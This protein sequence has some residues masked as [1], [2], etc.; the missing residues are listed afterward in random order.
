MPPH[1][2]ARLTPRDPPARLTPRRRAFEYHMPWDATGLVGD[3]DQTGLTEQMSHCRQQMEGFFGRPGDEAAAAPPG[4]RLQQALSEATARHE[5][6]LRRVAVLLGEELGKQL[7]AAVRR[8]VEEAVPEHPRSPGRERPGLFRNSSMKERSSLTSAEELGPS[9]ESER[10]TGGR[11]STM[12]LHADALLNPTR[13]FD[14]AA[15]T[16]LSAH[17]FGVGK[18]ASSTVEIVENTITGCC[19]EPEP[20]RTGG[21]ATIVLS[22]PFWILCN[23]VIALNSAFIIWATNHS[24]DTNGKASNLQVLIEPIFAAWYVV[25]LALK[26]AVH[27]KFFFTNKDL[28]FNILD[29]FLVTLALIE[30]F[31][32]LI[33][34]EQQ[35]FDATFLR[36]LRIFK[37]ARVL[38]MFRAVR[39]FADF[40]IMMDCV[41]Y[42]LWPLV[43]AIALLTFLSG[44][45]AI[46]FVQ[47]FA[48]ALESGEMDS[49]DVDRLL[50]AFGS[51]EA[52]MLSLLMA[53]T[54]GEDWVKLYDTLRPLG[55]FALGIFI[56]YIAFM[57]VAVMNIV[58]SVFLDKAMTIAQPN[59]E[60]VMLTKRE[61]DMADTKE[62]TELVSQMDTQKKGVITFSDFQQFMQTPK[63]RLY[64]D[65]RG[66]NVKDTAMFFRMLASSALTRPVEGREDHV[67]DLHSFVA[68]CMRLKG[69]ASSMDM[70][71][72]S[73]EM[74]ILRNT[75]EKVIEWMD[76][77]F[78][79]LKEAAGLPEESPHRVASLR[80]R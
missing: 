9:G 71:T 76:L 36:T 32:N 28:W 63:F 42:S 47:M 80:S 15:F 77:Q 33:E 64:F 79:Q 57:H 27:R 31:L 30:I 41:V 8:A 7:G 78:R 24:I 66:L 55:D 50:D 14:K 11:S 16:S 18:I 10:I 62:L 20:P 29:L 17:T 35:G 38:R 65:V 23:F 48:V 73:W 1:G 3:V 68:G 5:E 59:V 43:W 72:L 19:Q 44:L 12:Q 25:E 21:L 39:A 74:K 58:T 37:M 60:T 6:E 56:F 13:S 4:G 69:A 49:T 40:R 75:Q 26:I 45:F 67:V 52:A 70:Y 54:G 53:T 46:C 22:R 2:A 51:V 61:K 34:A